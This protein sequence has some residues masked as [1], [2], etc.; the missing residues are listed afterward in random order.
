LAFPPSALSAERPE[1]K[2]HGTFS[3]D[4]MYTVLPPGA[5][6]AIG[7]PRIISAEEAN[8]QMAPSE[9]VIG[10]VIG[11]AARAYSTWQLDSHEI[12]N[13]ELG[14]AAIAATW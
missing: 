11:D 1:P 5:I 3:G 14:G 10:V 8:K 4:P 6:P 9:P 12:V 7:E 13:D 2:V